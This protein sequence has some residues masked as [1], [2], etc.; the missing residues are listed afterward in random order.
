[1][2]PWR[3]LSNVSDTLDA[4]EAGI[5]L[6]LGTLLGTALVV[7]VPG[8][9]AW[10]LM[11]DGRPVLGGL[12]AALLALATF[13]VVRDVRARRMSW[14]SAVLAALWTLCVAFVVVRMVLA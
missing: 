12:V 5:I 1:M 7:G 9:L 13:G 8:M 10:T 4:F 11:R 14:L 3:F 2:K 6:V